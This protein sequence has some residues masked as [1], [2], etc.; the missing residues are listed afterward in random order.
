MSLYNE[1]AA[2]RIKYAKILK[3]GLTSI[4]DNHVEHLR[5]DGTMEGIIKVGES[6]PTFELKDGNGKTV[7]SAELLKRGPLP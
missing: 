6:A 2:L 4:M 5:A 7:S 3:P 1:L